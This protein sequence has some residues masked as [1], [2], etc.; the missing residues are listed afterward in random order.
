M[1]ILDEYEVEEVENEI[2][3]KRQKERFDV[4][5]V[6]GHRFV[7]GKL[8]FLLCWKGYKERTWTDESDMQCHSLVEKYFI[9]NP[10]AVA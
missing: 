7:N 5:K 4:E 10:T 9:S 8:Q 1:E 6:M 3:S 2:K